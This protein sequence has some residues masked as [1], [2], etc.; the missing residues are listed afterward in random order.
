MLDMPVDAFMQLIE[1]GVS[2]SSVPGTGFE[3]SNLGYALLGQVIEAATGESYQQYIK[4]N[5]WEPLGM[6]DTTYEMN[7]VP[8]NKLA[9]GY[10]WEGRR[11][12]REEMLHDGAF[13]AMVSHPQFDRPPVPRY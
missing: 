4:K 10:R 13:G 9:L 6:H 1:D 3:Y 8:A 12:T 7:D 2:L 5:I 11:W